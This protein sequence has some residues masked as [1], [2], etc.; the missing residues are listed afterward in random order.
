[1]K[2]ILLKT[3][4]ILCCI[5]LINYLSGCKSDD[6][7]PSAE[8][9]R[10]QELSATWGLG[11]VTNDGNDVTNQFI[12][13]SLTIDQFSF[14]TQ[15]GGNAWPANGT[16]TYVLVENDIKILERSDGVDVFLDQI[17]NDDLRLSFQITTLPG[18]RQEGITGQFIF[19][20]TKQ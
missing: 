19:S 12:D 5:G 4:V 11:S 8:S 2:N 10:L 13:F 6:D 14:T 7:G 18:G 15:N 3:L 1:M 16:F 9:I 17:S 20:L